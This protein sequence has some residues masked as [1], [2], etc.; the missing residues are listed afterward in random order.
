[1]LLSTVFRRVSTKL[2]L[3]LDGLSLFPLLSYL[4]SEEKN[5]QKG[6]IF[7]STVPQC[8]F[9]EMETTRRFYGVMAA[10]GFLEISENIKKY[11][12]PEFDSL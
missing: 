1:M 7:L 2:E 5:D 4:K 12:K 6:S 10:R 11:P 3:F 8:N 9:F